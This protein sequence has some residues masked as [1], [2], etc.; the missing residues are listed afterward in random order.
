M[1]D[2]PAPRRD[3]AIAVAHAAM[4]A[5]LRHGVS[6]TPAHYELF[7]A[8]HAPGAPPWR[9]EMDALLA[10]GAPLD[11]LHERLFGPAR[12][13]AEVERVSAALDA[14]LEDAAGAMTGAVDD[15]S[16]YGETLAG[17]SQA[18]ARR[19]A[20]APPMIAR[21]EEETR[22]LREKGE[23]MA[24]RLGEM[25]ERTQSL[26][27]EL[28]AARRDAESDPLT[29]LANRRAFDAA[30]AAAV[31]E[32]GAVLLLLDVDHFKAVN[33]RHGHATGDLMLAE[34]AARLREALRPGELG[35][36]VG[37]EEMAAI[38]RRPGAEDAAAAAEALRRAVAQSAVLPGDEG[39]PVRVTVSVGAARARPGEAPRALYERADRL[40]YAA[41]QAGR[42]Q[43]RAELEAGALAW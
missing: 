5:M 42:D 41:K 4:Q 32:G 3:P 17:L 10:A 8:R 19:G 6:P 14:T 30:L 33:D 29:G 35:A 25:A 2:A 26:R 34:V 15:A 13:E 36:R 37:G 28:E 39:A 11:A 20:Q 1:T 40:L 7:F 18:L 22:S 24:R 12:R 21:L 38:L 43:V 27:A 23:A 31:A 9:A 16:R